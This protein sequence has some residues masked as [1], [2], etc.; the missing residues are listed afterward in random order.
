MLGEY[1]SYVFKFLLRDLFEVELVLV[2]V[3]KFTGVVDLTLHQHLLDMLPLLRLT[4]GQ[5]EDNGG[6]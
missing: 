3:F 5:P 4:V 2:L 6:V 1:V